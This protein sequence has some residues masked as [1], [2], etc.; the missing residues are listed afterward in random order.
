MINVWIADLTYTQ[1][2]ISSDTVPAA[3]G[4]I[5]QYLED[6]ILE[7]INIELFK[8]PEKLISKLEESVP[9][10]IGF[11]NYIWNSSLSIE[12]SK[13]VRQ[14][15]GD[16]TI[17]FGGPNFPNNDKEQ[18]RFLYNNSHIYYYIIKEAEY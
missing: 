14:I 15:S 12:F 6:N 17:V 13:L 4:I 1:Q 10:V 7:D 9:D 16:V 11:S 5:A 2:S 18:K 8:Y 3:I